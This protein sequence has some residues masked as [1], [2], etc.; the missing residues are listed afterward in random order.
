[1][2]EE[3]SVRLPKNVRPLKYRITLTSNFSDFTFKGSEEIDIFISEPTSEITLHA[4]DLKIQSAYLKYKNILQIVEPKETHL[5]EKEETLIISFAEILS[6][7]HATLAIAFSGE[8]NNK[9]HGFY[10]G[11]YT[12]NGEDKYMAATQ[13]EATDARRAFPCWDEPD[14]KAT[15]R[16]QLIMPSNLSAISNMPIWETKEALP[17]S[18]KLTAVTFAKTPLMSTY[19]L[20]FII[21]EFESLETTTQEGTLVRVFT[22]PGKKEQGKFALDVAKRTLEFYNDYFG[23]PY[24]L[25]KIDLIAIPDFASGAMENWGAITYRETA[26]LIDE[27]NSSAATRQR[28]AMVIAHELA[29]QWFG[30]LVTMKWW[31]HLWLNEGFATWISY[32][33]VDHLFPEWDIWTQFVTNEF[34]RAFALDSLENSHPI[35]VEVK[36]PSEIREIFDAVSYSKGASIIR[37]LESYLGK[38]KFCDGLRR[39]LNCHLYSNASTE[40][41]WTALEEVSGEPIKTIMDGWTKQIG[42]PVLNATGA[43]NLLYVRQSRF[44]TSG[45]NTKDLS[46]WQI[47]IRVKSQNSTEI[48]A[49]RME[50]RSAMVPLPHHR[51]GWLNLNAGETGFYRVKYPTSFLFELKSAVTLKGLTPVERIGLENDCFAISRAGLMPATEF[52]NLATAY[53]DEDNYAVC[54]DLAAN[55]NE[56]GNLLALEQCYWKFLPYARDIFLGLGERLGWDAKPEEDHLTAMLRSLAIGQLGR[57]IN[58][59]TI[60]EARRR[61]GRFVADRT[62]LDPNLRL[63]CY[64]IVIKYGDALD[65][66]R[67]L[68]LYREMPLQEEKIRCLQSLGASLKSDLLKQTLEFSISPEVRSQDTLYGVLSVAR[69]HKGRELAWKF[70]QDNWDIFHNRYQSGGIN[71]LTYII[72]GTTENFTTLAKA[73]EVEEFFKSHPAPGAERKIKQS[74]ERIRSNAAWLERD[75]EPIAKWLENYNYR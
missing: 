53:K 57:Y 18:D 65:Y 63:P 27:K 71:L 49:M 58:L 24:P 8:L 45:E 5:N 66:E 30:N 39:Y 4:A 38:E 68:K 1:M 69:N 48:T 67:V 22:T 47:P 26:L 52:L 44:F 31:T 61:F 46:C 36:H 15:F 14:L 41:L 32:L 37:M 12:V 35:E 17:K 62:T 72:G 51:N 74:L 29:H 56:L 55:I 75:G 43:K 59:E 25:P 20:A 42:Y 11:K 3:K 10:R 7:G 23:I 64:T 16:L 33:A 50:H 40:D 60:F 21:G 54:A 73:E 6:V 2:P 9:M 13:F 19:L 28:V 70:L 34:G